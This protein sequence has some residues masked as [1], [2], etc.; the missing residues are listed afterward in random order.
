MSDKLLERLKTWNGPHIGSLGRAAA[1]RIEWLEAKLLE[2]ESEA[3]STEFT[4]VPVEPSNDT[5]SA[6]VAELHD[7][8][9]DIPG[10]GRDN[11]YEV[12]SRV[13]R[14]MIRDEP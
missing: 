4:I 3:L 1:D 2:L 10:V 11:A 9:P 14:T 7:L 13:Y 12:L 6:A 5:L 8:D